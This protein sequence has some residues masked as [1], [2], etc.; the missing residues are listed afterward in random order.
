MNEAIF[1]QKS[2]NAMD[3]SK[4]IKPAVAE[5]PM[6]LELAKIVYGGQAENEILLLQECSRCPYERKCRGRRRFQIRSD[7]IERANYRDI[8]SQ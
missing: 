5:M 2:M 8:Q 7:K 1:F 6:P 3:R 4:L